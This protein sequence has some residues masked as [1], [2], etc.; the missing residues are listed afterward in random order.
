MSVVEIGSISFPG[1]KPWIILKSWPI[2]LGQG[3]INRES[4]SN[5]SRLGYLQ[6][7]VTTGV[8]SVIRAEAQRAGMPRSLD[9]SKAPPSRLQCRTRRSSVK[10]F[11]HGHIPTGM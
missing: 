9:P 8:C 3:G 7:V 10:H 11:W 5:R 1:A 6:Y 4:G 2:E